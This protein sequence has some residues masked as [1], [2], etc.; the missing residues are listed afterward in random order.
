[1]PS[2][3]RKECNITGFDVTVNRTDDVLTFTIS[4]PCTQLTSCRMIKAILHSALEAFLADAT[5]TEVADDLTAGVGCECACGYQE[6]EYVFDTLSMSFPITGS[7]TTDA[8]GG[9]V[10]L[11]V[12]LPL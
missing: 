6:I 11:E 7:A 12:T 10:V 3:S 8:D 1:M 2:C 5:N 9:D 4:D